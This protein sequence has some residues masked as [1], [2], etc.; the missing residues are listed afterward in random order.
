MIKYINDASLEMVAGGIA[1][2]R[3]VVNK[4]GHVMPEESLKGLATS[5]AA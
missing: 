5:A 2:I 3:E 4:G 1:A